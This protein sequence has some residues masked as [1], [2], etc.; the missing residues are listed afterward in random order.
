[1]HIRSAVIDYLYSEAIKAI[2]KV[3]NSHLVAG[4]NRRR[5]NNCISRLELE[6][7]VRASACPPEG[8]E[9][10]TLCS[11]GKHEHFIGRVIFHLAHIY[12]VTL[13]GCQHSGRDGDFDVC[14]D[15]SSV[16]YHLTA[17]FLF[18]LN[19]LYHSG[20]LGGKGSYNNAPFYIAHYLVYILY[21]FP[22]GDGPTRALGVCGVGYE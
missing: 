5:K 22:L 1:M 2:L 20:E 6:M 4:D 21:N 8:R 15:T 19:N 3:L 9:L 13:F 10:L 18:N 11:G 17:V 12:N 16:S 7:L 14:F